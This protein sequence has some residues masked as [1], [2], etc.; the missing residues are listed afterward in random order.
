M[1][2]VSREWCFIRK[3]TVKPSEVDP[4][5]HALINVTGQ[6][7]ALAVLQG[8]HNFLAV[9]VE[10]AAV[11]LRVAEHGAEFFRSTLSVR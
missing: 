8:K 9:Q 3:R 6:V 7:V 10:A 5:F 4:I 1:V 2:F 11:R